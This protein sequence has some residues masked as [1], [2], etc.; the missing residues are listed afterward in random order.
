[1]NDVA[2]DGRALV[3]HQLGSSIAAALQHGIDLFVGDG[4][5]HALHMEAGGLGPYKE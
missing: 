4:G 1:M 5:G 3:G 2:L